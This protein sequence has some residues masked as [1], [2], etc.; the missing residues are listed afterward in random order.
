MPE[1]LIG[2]DE[3][4]E[5]RRDL[6]RRRAALLHAVGAV[7]ESGGDADEGATF[8]ERPGEG[9]ESVH[10]KDGAAEFGQAAM[11][12]A[13][14]ALLFHGGFDAA[15]SDDDLLQ[16][17]EEF[18]AFFLREAGVVPRAPGETPHEVKHER[19]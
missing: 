15:D 9:V 14:F 1:R 18:G 8:Q 3:R 19:R 10:S 16:M 7:R 17:P 5:K 4:D 12:S 2:G 13:D 6:A 11:H